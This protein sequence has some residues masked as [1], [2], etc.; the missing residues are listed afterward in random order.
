[1]E[2]HSPDR[3]RHRHSG[4]IDYNDYGQ[5]RYRA[6]SGRTAQQWVGPDYTARNRQTP[7]TAKRQNTA[8][9]GSRYGSRYGNSYSSPYNKNSGQAASE[10]YYGT[11]SGESLYPYTGKPVKGTIAADAAKERNK[12]S[13]AIPRATAKAAW[14]AARV[15]DPSYG[16]NSAWKV[17][18]QNR[19]DTRRYYQDEIARYRKEH[20]PAAYCK[21]GTVSGRGGGACSG[22]GGLLKRG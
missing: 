8:G 5:T 17:S 18:K 4:S 12:N 11:R 14:D 3:N 20:R 2:Y 10:K 13:S 15:P 16:G 19:V 21:D 9:Y 6:P 1:M 22:H 7:N